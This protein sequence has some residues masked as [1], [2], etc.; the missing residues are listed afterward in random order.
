[1]RPVCFSLQPS[2][3]RGGDSMS[4]LNGFVRVA[5]ALPAV[6][7]ADCAANVDRILDLLVR[8]ERDEVGVLVFPELSLTGYTC[9]DLFHQAELQHGALEALARLCRES[10]G[11]FGGLAVVGLPLVVDDQLFNCAAVLQRGSVLGV[12]PK[13]YLPSYGE[14][15]EARWFAP[16]S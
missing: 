16:A 4:D 1:N 8:A 7:P 3:F 11:V 6:R 5:A 10:V 9:A 14:F 12:V 15:Y 13:S 2:A